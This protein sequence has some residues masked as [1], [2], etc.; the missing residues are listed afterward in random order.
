MFEFPGEMMMNVLWYYRPEQTE[1]ERFPKL[2]KCEIFASY[3]FQR[4]KVPMQS[5][6]EFIE[7]ICPLL[8]ILV[9]HMVTV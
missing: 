5:V 8:H 1:I 9:V 4:K 2:E 3:V 7:I 6:D